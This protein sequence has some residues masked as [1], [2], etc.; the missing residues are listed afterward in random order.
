MTSV[1]ITLSGNS[2]VLE[3][4][5]FPPITLD[6]KF[7][8]ECGL[9]DF[10]T[11]NCIPNID[12]SN[13]K[14]IYGDEKNIIFIPTGSYEISDIYEY[15]KSKLDNSI[16][17]KMC[18][19]KN[20]LKC[21]IFSNVLIDFTQTNT[22]GTLLGFSSQILQSGELH[23]SDQPI[24]INR[25]NTIRVECSIITSSYFNNE[26]VHTL[27]AFFP[28][29]EAGDKIVESPQHVIYLPVT[30][31]TIH[32]IT[33]R[34]VDQNNCLINSQRKYCYT[35]THKTGE[36]LTVNYNMYIYKC[37]AM[38]LSRKDNKIN[39]NATTKSNMKRAEEAG[40][41][42]STT[43]KQKKL[44]LNQINREFLKSLGFDLKKDD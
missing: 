36:N 44:S 29:V 26:S 10:Q 24:E 4:D 16:K 38:I 20:T 13:N 5:F 37:G 7:Q 28:T 43:K 35:T 30:V 6:D 9:V 34:F 39:G 42:K 41:S 22:I 8:Y 21:E 11:F 19:N 33:L 12:E 27:H 31:G 18:V 1:T 3:S 15:I 32:N 14:F 23:I 17:F 25:I 40:T 2:S